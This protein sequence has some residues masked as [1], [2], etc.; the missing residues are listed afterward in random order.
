MVGALVGAV[1]GAR[2]GRS[3][4]FAAALCGLPL[5][6]ATRIQFVSDGRVEGG[7][8]VVSARVGLFVAVVVVA[9]LIARRQRRSPVRL[10][11]LVLL[12]GLPALVAATS[13]QYR[14]H[15]GEVGL[16]EGAELA[17]LTQLEHG[18]AP[19]LT[20][21]V[22]PELMRPALVSAVAGPSLRSLRLSRDL[23]EPLER[24]L[25]VVIAAVVLP[26]RWAL[27]FGLVSIAFPAVGAGG[28]LLVEVAL[29]GSLILA[30]AERRGAGAWPLAAL[31][32]VLAGAALLWMP[33]L[34]APLLVAVLVAGIGDRRL[35][36]TAALLGVAA[37][38][39]AATGIGLGADQI[40]DA[41]MTSGAIALG[42]DRPF[43][44]PTDIRWVGV[45]MALLVGRAQL[46]ERRRDPAMFALWLFSVLVAVRGLV[47]GGGSLEL[48][49]A[50]VACTP[51]V[52]VVIARLPGERA[53][54]AL[55]VAVLLTPLVEG[56]APLAAA[57]A[58]FGSASRV[59]IDGLSLMRLPPL[60]DGRQRDLRVMIPVEQAH[61]LAPAVVGLR[62]LDADATLF[63]FTDHPE[64]YFLVDRPPPS[65]LLAVSALTTDAAERALLTALDDD[66]PTRVIY[67]SFTD[68]DAP[69]G[70][71]NRA[72]YP[73]IAAWIA[74]RYRPSASFGTF[75]ILGPGD[76]EPVTGIVAA[77]GYDVTA[78]GWLPLRA[79]RPGAGGDGHEITP[80][81]TEHGVSLPIDDELRAR[82][83]RLEISLTC[84]AQR[85]V[86]IRWRVPSHDGL[87]T[88][89]TFD[90]HA[91][92]GRYLV[93]I[94]VVPAWVWPVRIE[95]L[96]I[97]ASGCLPERV[98]A[99]S[100]PLP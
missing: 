76:W 30:R 11:R 23:M 85:E 45:V 39:V 91:G 35:V 19:A 28:S 37:V 38:A 94:S 9:G 43:R 18:Q 60:A 5:A 7:F 3:F 70:V 44:A 99:A 32:G 87:S 88:G 81:S 47:A 10:R 100:G 49:D 22:G 98:M 89:L 93:P 77:K 58:R 50:I 84:D 97:I 20:R 52:A 64:L 34:G 51:L 8:D 90:A 41:L 83:E 80:V 12:A 57:A 26:A 21:G 24:A 53:L 31:V 71:S 69:G 63:D 36:A 74:G 59:A 66:P 73:R 62:Q 79:G 17:A 78:M 56:H 92:S 65:G 15:G 75:I 95:G 86:A 27:L 42:Q 25:M 61:A 6:V 1:I 72:R 14:V 33:T 48:T 68:R 4:A 2:R 40:G 46:P 29:L 96:T 67:R 82:T 16:A 54:A 13:F 55:T